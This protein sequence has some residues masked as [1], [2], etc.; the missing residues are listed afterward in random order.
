MDNNGISTFVWRT[1]SQELDKDKSY[2]NTPYPYYYPLNVIP[3]FQYSRDNNVS[4]PVATNASPI[5]SFKLVRCEDQ[6]EL[7]IIDTMTNQH[8][9]H[10]LEYKGYDLIINPA[11]TELTFPSNYTQKEGMHYC[12][13]SDG[14]NTW[15]SEHFVWRV[16]MSDFLKITYWHDEG[17]ELPK[18]HVRYATPYRNVLY[19]NCQIG[20]PDYPAKETVKQRGGYYF[21]DY[22]ESAKE[23]RFTIHATEFM[24]DGMSRIWQHRFIKIESKGRVHYPTRLLMSKPRWEEQ[25]DVAGVD[26]AFHTDTVSF[27]VGTGKVS[28]G[29]DFDGTDYNEDFLTE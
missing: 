20:K 6:H 28:N 25:G 10:A 21:P 17:F 2:I 8:G 3:R 27:I 14:T 22:Q 29:A 23:F 19:L 13:M 11:T 9:L 5:T 12:L 7:E 1:S 15:R 18:S 24:L 16:D 26:F 4:E